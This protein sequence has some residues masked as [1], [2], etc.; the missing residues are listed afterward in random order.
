VSYNKTEGTFG[1]DRDFIRKEKK[2]RFTAGEHLVAL[3]CPGHA[4]T[5]SDETK[6]IIYVLK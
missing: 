6:V 4:E 2:M 1:S 5:W 3:T